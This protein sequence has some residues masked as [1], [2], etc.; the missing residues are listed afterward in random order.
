MSGITG[1][2]RGRGSYTDDRAALL[3]GNPP[4]GPY[5]AGRGRGGRGGRGGKVST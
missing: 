2:G 3:A 5:V 1:R 4:A